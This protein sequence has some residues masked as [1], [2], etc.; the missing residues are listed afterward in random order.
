[1]TVSL[2]EVVKK[3]VFLRSGWPY[4]RGGG[5]KP[6]R[7]WS[8]ANVK[9]S[10]YFNR[11]CSATWNWF[12]YF[13]FA[14]GYDRHWWQLLVASIPKRYF[15][16][17]LSS[18]PSFFI[19]CLCRLCSHLHLVSLCVCVNTLSESLIKRHFSLNFLGRFALHR[20]TLP[21]VSRPP[22]NSKYDLLQLKLTPLPLRRVFALP[23]SSTKA[24]IKTFEKANSTANLIQSNQN[25]SLTSY[26]QHPSL[27]P[28]WLV[29]SKSFKWCDSSRKPWF[30]VDI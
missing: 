5:V 25:W 17:F 12:C 29:Q 15:P 13:A 16:A 1:M 4:G 14:R 3:T 18:S 2:S 10:R 24:Q 20:I 23:T 6:H 28:W 9:I 21:V 26:I 8:Y 30:C 7:P 27:S 22:K 11:N 19:L